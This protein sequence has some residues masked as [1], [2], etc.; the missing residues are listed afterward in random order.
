M[1]YGLIVYVFRSSYVL[2]RLVSG[3]CEWYLIVVEK[4][5]VD[6]SFGYFFCDFDVFVGVYDVVCII[7]WELD[8]EFKGYC[9]G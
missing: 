3:K 4:W 8:C 6:Y 1:D 5:Y 9:D 2:L 7:C